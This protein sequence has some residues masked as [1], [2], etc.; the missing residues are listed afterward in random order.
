VRDRFNSSADA[1]LLSKE[2]GACSPWPFGYEV[3][4]R[5]VVLRGSWPDVGPEATAPPSGAADSRHSRVRRHE[6]VG[7]CPLRHSLLGSLFSQHPFGAC[8]WDR[9]CRSDSPS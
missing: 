5:Q 6:E 8:H 4:A 9:I 2:Q 1:Q 3:A 7:S